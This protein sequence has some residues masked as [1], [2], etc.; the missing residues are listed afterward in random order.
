[1]SEDTNDRIGENMEEINE[2]LNDVQL[3]ASEQE[4]VEHIH[5]DN[6][7]EN[8]NS[9][10]KGEHEEEDEEDDDF[11]DFNEAGESD[12]NPDD[13]EDDDFGDFDDVEYEEPKE[14][15]PSPIS[16]TTTNIPTFDEEVLADKSQFNEKLSHIINELFPVSNLPE[17]IKQDQQTELLN[18]RSKTIYEQMSTMPY[19]HPH[20]WTKSKIRH[21]LLI[22][23]GIPI[24]LDEI[25][26]T[27]SA[28]GHRPQLNPIPTSTTTI[29]RKSIAAEDI[30]WKGFEIPEFTQLGIDQQQK[31]AMLNSTVDSLSKIEFDNLNNISV[32]YLENA[33]PEAIDDKL[34]Q[35][36]RHY[37]ELIQLSSCWK[38]NIN[39]LQNDFEIYENVVQSFIGYSQKL[40]REEILDNL[41]RL[42][43]TKKKKF[44]KS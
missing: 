14:E 15:P 10:H 8:D 23:L 25:T 41:K 36:E 33:P 22:K 40:R 9:E 42:K 2:Q 39:D 29:R 16:T 4:E 30:D 28:Q 1:M 26:D 19:L 5:N 6:N 32:G 27:P 34:I 18:E 44:W 12:A 17:I 31:L 37:Q 43:N 7:D 13:D 21:N 35:L 24:N 20:S 11:D 3:D 38:Q